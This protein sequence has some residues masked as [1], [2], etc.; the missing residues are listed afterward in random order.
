MTGIKGIQDDRIVKELEA[1]VELI[2]Q[3]AALSYAQRVVGRRETGT[4]SPADVEQINAANP[5]NFLLCYGNLTTAHIQQLEKNTT[6]EQ[7]GH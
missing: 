5:D 1:K 4:L 3:F 6:A 2:G 7:T